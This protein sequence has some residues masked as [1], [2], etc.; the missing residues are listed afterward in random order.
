MLNIPINT[1]D[2][3]RPLSLKEKALFISLLTLI[4][5]ALLIP[6]MQ[7]AKGRELGVEQRGV[8][9]Q[10]RLLEEERRLVLSLLAEASLPEVVLEKATKE[11]LVL[12]KI[13]GENIKVV[14]VKE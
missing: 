13:L 7:A 5:V 12:E 11:N 2:K 4:F 1:R 10:Q 14:T 3:K 9:R 6:V 8:E